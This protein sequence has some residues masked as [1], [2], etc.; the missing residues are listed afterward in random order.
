MG[1]MTIYVDDAEIN[2]G[3]EKVR[4]YMENNNSQ[5]ANVFDILESLEGTIRINNKKISNKKES[6][7]KASRDFI[8]NN[9]GTIN[10]LNHTVRMY[11]KSK[12]NSVKL[13]QNEKEKL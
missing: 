5:I 1:K 7:M 11:F 2:K 8:N 3:I 9:N 12:D 4:T 6:F 10:V 13:V